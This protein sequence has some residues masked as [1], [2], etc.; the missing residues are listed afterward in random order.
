MPS[1][2][3]KLANSLKLLQDLQDNDGIAIFKSTELSRTH[4]ERLQKNG[5]IKEVIKGWYISANPVEKKADSTSWFTAYWKFCEKYLNKR[6]GKNWCLSPEQSLSIQTGNWTI[7]KQLI[8][9]S[10]KANNNVTSLVFDTAIVDVKATL[11]PKKEIIEK[12]GV[13]IFSLAFALVSCTPNFFI[14]NPIDTRTALTT[15]SDDSEILSILLDGGNSV[16]AARIAGAFRNIGNYRIA[17]NIIQTMKAVG[18]NIRE[19]DPFSSKLQFTITNRDISPYAN[20][21]IM[22]WQQN[23]ESVIRLFPKPPGI[24]ENKTIYLQS[25]EDFYKTDAYHS[26]SI[27]GYKVSPEL[28]EKVMHGEWD[29]DGDQQDKTHIDAM[30][31]RGYFLAFESVKKSIEKVFAGQN[32]GKTADEDHGEWYRQMFSPSV[33]AGILKPSDLAGYRNSQVF[34]SQSAHFPMSPLGVR[35]AMPVLFEMLQNE[36]EASVRAVLGHFIFVYI[37]PYMDGNGRIA[38]FLMN[39]MLA[40]GGYPWTTIP[41][42]RREEYMNALERASVEHNIEDFVRF[43]AELVAGNMGKLDI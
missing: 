34:I 20:R 21:I 36:S 14:K 11:P 40:S 15:I 8:V 38:R 12:N 32:P 17:D 18:H 1:L 35:D 41:L 28:I 6:F 23:R 33:T 4:R 3:E 25:L 16:V 24:P 43:V 9:R 5:F 42:E 19:T 27:E 10:P 31:A 26:L 30:A 39:V 22:M 2:Q 29:P 13:R 7:P 37:H